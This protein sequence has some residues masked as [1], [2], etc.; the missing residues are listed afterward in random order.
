MYYLG[1]D[2]TNKYLIISVFT[3]DEVLYFYQ[4]KSSRNVSEN[5]NVIID[6]AMKTVNIKPKDLSAVV[7]TNGPGSFTGVRIGLSIAKVLTSILDIKLYTLSSLHYYSGLSNAPVILDAR[8]KKAYYGT[9]EKGNIIS[10]EMV[11]VEELPT[12]KSVIG[13]G[14]LVGLEENYSNL[15]THFLELKPYWNEESY[16]DAIPQYLKSN[17]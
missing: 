8:S 7:V 1:I 16:F 17:I 4:E 15:E 12:F 6:E 3:D 11:L 2:T 9:F 5:A 10:Q 13:D 14:S